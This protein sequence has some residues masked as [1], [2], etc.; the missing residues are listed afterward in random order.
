ME[1][2]KREFYNEIFAKNER[3]LINKK[4]EKLRKNG[5]YNTINY[6][7]YAPYSNKQEKKSFSLFNFFFKFL[8]FLG[9]IG[10]FYLLI[11]NDS[12][13]T[14]DIF[15]KAKNILN[16]K[17]KIIN[18]N[19]DFSSEKVFNINNEKNYIDINEIKKMEEDLEIP[20]KK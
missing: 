18:F 16:N 11:R 15:E 8:V 7:N 5:T 13:L 19:K 9:I 3:E 17:A 1:H 12:N 6:K 20:K 2:N 10:C 14:K 4:N